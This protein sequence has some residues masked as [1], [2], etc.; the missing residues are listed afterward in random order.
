MQIKQFMKFIQIT[1][2][3]AIAIQPLL[4][5]SAPTS[6]GELKYRLLSPLYSGGGAHI[7]RTESPQ[8]IAMNPAVAAGYQHIVLDANYINLQ[9]LAGS[10]GMGHAASLSFSYPTRRGVL[11]LAGSFLD[12][13]SFEKSA[14]DLGTSGSLNIAFSK[15]IYS[16]TWFGFGLVGDVGQLDGA[17]Q[18]GGALNV[19]FL[20]FPKGFWNKSNFSWGGSITGLGYR[21]GSTSRGYFDSVPGN[22]SPSFGAAFDLVN[23]E[24]FRWAVRSDVR[25][26]S[27]SDL[28]VGFATDIYLGKTFNLSASSSFS[29]G[30]AIAGSAGTLIP[31]A[32]IGFNFSLNSKTDRTRQLELR[33]TAAPLY[34][35]IWGFG[36]GLFLPLGVKDANPPEITVEYPDMRYISPNYDGIQDEL[37]LPY[38]VSDER[39]IMT[40]KWRVVDSMNNTVRTWSNKE[41][42]PENETVKNLFARLFARKEGTPLPDNFRWDGITDSGSLAADGDYSV[43]LQFSDD[44]G[45]S[46]EAGPF[47]LVV[48]TVPPEISLEEPEGLELIFSP[49]GD[50]SKD[51]F[52]FKQT[53]ST[54]QLWEAEIQDF[55]GS[56]IKTWTWENESPESIEW[57]GQNDSGQVV[58]DNVYRYA[59]RST[60]K[61]G[62]SNEEAIEGIIIDTT[63]PEIA[64]T[65]NRNT[66]SPGTA[67]PI[68]TLTLK[69][70]ISLKTGIV[71]WNMQIKYNNGTV[72]RTWSREKD[73]TLPRSFDFNGLDNAGQT[74]P[75]GKYYGLLKLDYNNGFRPESA[76]PLFTIDMTPPEA[77]VSANW[78]IF[79]PQAGSS[80]S[81]VVFSQETSIEES[82]TGTLTD[83]AGKVV[84][85]WTWIKQADDT[86]IWD[87][88]NA[89]GRLIPDGEYLYSLSSVDS[90]G[91]AGES[92]PAAVMVDTSAVE[93]FLTASLD[94]FGPTGNGIKD[95]VNFFMSTRTDAA[96]ADWK[97]TVRNTSGK[98][99]RSW[100]GK[101]TP[102]DLQAWNG[103]DNTGKTVAD[104][105]YIAAF[106]VNYVKGDSARTE[107]GPVEVDTVAP[108]IN[109]ETSN[110]IFSPDGDN[111]RDVLTIR[112]SSSNE[113][114]FRAVI[115]N[116]ENKLV[117]TWV[118]TG[119]LDSVEWD[120][121]DD[122]GMPCR[123]LAT[124]MW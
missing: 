106:V 87:G 77:A 94:V 89:E 28:A 58:Q 22:I 98:E 4:G 49:D 36:A 42:H 46:A 86:L 8:G 119:S 116:A 92:P 17:T 79:S 78:K 66:F 44:N 93:A 39:Y 31:S 56:P 37:L 24:N 3:T 16:D 124:D 60:D 115:S 61:A 76:S 114:F 29:L 23:K 99:I 63:R 26:P 118:W 91:N 100:S 54:E 84:N 122:S 105:L 81:Q 109:V 96:A 82:W 19:G 102:P 14:M 1:A 6:A 85:Q 18:G 5:E 32:T 95:T 103:K 123:M 104:G 113:E 2:L 34:S 64:L 30:D 43:Y 65:I 72:G 33:A 35:G 70:D 27:I 9:D 68:S 75:E 69:P 50:G 110:K 101:G 112:Q 48:D 74:L 10:M 120:G 20:H 108:T 7:T 45:N 40:F 97:L 53:G 73:G 90:A 62:N 12:T 11:T 71:D 15:E 57:N 41:E 38:E 117:R 107:S 25:F 88:R 51:E 47:P 55:S 83:K 21:F 67:S 13:S 52:S 121:K 59:L 111:A 80:R